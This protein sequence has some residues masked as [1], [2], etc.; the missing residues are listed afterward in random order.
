MG[1]ARAA[2][3]RPYPDIGASIIG[4]SQKRGGEALADR[5]RHGI[6]I[7][8]ARHGKAEADRVGL[9]FGPEQTTALEHVTNRGDLSLVVG[10]V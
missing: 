2:G 9:V 10:Y 1:H 4:G 8:S 5:E 7:A 6:T 3:T